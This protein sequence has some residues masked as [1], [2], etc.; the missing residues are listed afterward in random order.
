MR[1]KE[2][3]KWLKEGG[4]VP[5]S[6]LSE[7]ELLKENDI[8]IVKEDSDYY[9]A[10]YHPHRVVYQTVG[11]KLHGE[12]NFYSRKEGALMLQE[13]TSYLHGEVVK[14]E[15]WWDNGQK[16]YEQHYLH[17]K[18]HGKWE[19]WWDNGQKACEQHFL[20]GMR[21]GVFKEWDDNGSLAKDE[22]YLYGNKIK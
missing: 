6:L 22:E 21:H 9:M 3:N 18:E 13:R 20:H 17:G 5:I 14:T 12:H 10:R 2:I 7:V 4:E 8:K 16:R 1:T 11:E 15:G 19:G